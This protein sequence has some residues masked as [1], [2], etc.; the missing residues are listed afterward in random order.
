M[1]FQAAA[2]AV[3]AGQAVKATRLVLEAI[4][5]LP[6]GGSYN[7]AEPAQVMGEENARTTPLLFAG[8][9]APAITGQMLRELEIP[10]LLLEGETTAV[11]YRLINDQLAKCIPG[12]RR[13]VLKKANHDAPAHHPLAFS[14]AVLEF[15]SGK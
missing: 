8:P 5:Q 2:D 14:A 3:K 11:H 4:F 6:P 13:L 15:V 9:P 7:E 12:A 1:M 10:T